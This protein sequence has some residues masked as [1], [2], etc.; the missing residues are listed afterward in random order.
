MITTRRQF[1]HSLLAALAASSVRGGAANGKRLRLAI[2]NETFPNWKL[3]DVCRTIRRLGYAGV[4]VMPATLGPDPAALAASARADLRRAMEGEG[5][6][7]V[8]LHAVLSAPQ[9]LHITTP[10]EA[11]RRRSWE[12]VR[13]LIELSADLG[14]RAGGGVMVIG[15]GK[16]RATTAGSTAADAVKRFTAGLA[17]S[18]PF[19][20]ARGVTLLIE[21]LAPHLCDVVNTLAEAV[22]M[23]KEINHPA[24][25][26]MFDTHNT[27][28]ETLPHD[29][30]LKTYRTHIRH[31]HL[32][33][34]DGRHPGTGGYDF[35]T[36]LG[37]LKEIGYRG[38]VSVEVFDF[39]PGGE[40]IAAESAR[41][42]RA[43]E[44][45]A[46]AETE[47]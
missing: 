42:I 2:C 32:N 43:W 27:P 39:A 17:E 47:R 12:Y 13:R 30:L 26:T 7:F 14:G 21:P 40:K 16:Q 35:K 38:W 10:D 5:V 19:A 29:E 34:M 33:E 20:A 1:T 45:A 22:A 11:V 8:G 41:F 15:S 46:K 25:A 9:G 37:A 18:A 23:V 6:A 3:G 24:V 31:V 44:A 28:A 4:E 36:P